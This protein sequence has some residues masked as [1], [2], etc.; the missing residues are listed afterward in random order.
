MALLTRD[1]IRNRVRTVSGEFNK[2]HSDRNIEGVRA[3]IG[4]FEADMSARGLRF[5]PIFGWCTEREI[6]WVNR[7]LREGG[8]PDFDKITGVP[9][10]KNENN[11][12]VIESFV[13][14]LELMK[15]ARNKQNDQLALVA[16]VMG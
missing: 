3:I 1:D 9:A 14:T 10:Y 15:Y 8:Y 16:E 11:Q 7:K 2:R 12:T 5:S 6:N 4:E 13:D